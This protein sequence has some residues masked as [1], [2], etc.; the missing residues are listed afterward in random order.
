M[1]KRVTL[2]G[3]L[4][5]LVL[6]VGACAPAAEEPAPEPVVEE[7]PPPPPPPTYELTEVAISEEVPEFTSQ[8]IELLGIKVGDI[9]N[10]VADVL[11]DLSIGTIVA[12]EDYVT[13]YQDGG[14]VLYTF[15]QTGV[16]RRIEITT[17]FADEIAD[18]NLKAW[19][20]DGDQS[21]L[22]EWLGPEESTETVPENNNATE[23]VYDSQGLRFIQYFIEG[24]DYFAVRFSEM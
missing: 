20:E 21:L 4:S 14:V 11:G 8:N 9:T 15:R 19:L 13:V 3:L 18:P 24:Q 5:I 2:F 6:T 12:P 17:A 23:F 1:F 16:A 10:D 7:P 22:R